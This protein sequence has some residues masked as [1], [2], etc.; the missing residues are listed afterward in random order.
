MG[1]CLLVSWTEYPPNPR[2][3]QPNSIRLASPR[4]ACP[5]HRR[6]VNN[7]VAKLVYSDYD[8]TAP[9][10]TEAKAGFE[11]W[12]EP[13]IADTEAKALELFGSGN[14]KAAGEALTQLA[15]ESTAEATARWTALWQTIMVTNLDGGVASVDEDGEWDGL[16]RED[17]DVQSKP[18]EI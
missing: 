5:A 11:S 16:K 6:R 9:M 10:V 1:E 2:P 7:A 17:F 15:V 13:R 3:K 14:H 8:R 12:L 4:L 18:S